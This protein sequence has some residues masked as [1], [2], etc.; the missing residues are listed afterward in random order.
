M[1]DSFDDI[2][3]ALTSGCSEEEFLEMRCPECGA[4]LDLT[5][6]PSGRKFFVRCQEDSTHLA[7]HDEATTAPEWWRKKVGSGW[8]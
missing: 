5:V 8:Y 3:N 1:E 7:M 6:H 4:E 2:R